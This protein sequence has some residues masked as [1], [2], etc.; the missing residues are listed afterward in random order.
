MGAILAL[1]AFSGKHVGVGKLQVLRNT[2][3]PLSLLKYGDLLPTIHFMLGF[4]G[5]ILSKPPKLKV[6]LISSW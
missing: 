3:A 6:T 1:Q 4:G 2:G 5:W